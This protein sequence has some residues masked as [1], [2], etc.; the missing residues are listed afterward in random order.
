[1]TRRQAA[2]PWPLLVTLVLLALL[3]TSP[4]AA[5]L[6]D[7]A[8]DGWHTW[9]VAVAANVPEWCCYAWNSGIA[10]RTSCDLDGHLGGYHSA[11]DASGG[12]GQLQLYAL[13]DSGRATRIRALSPRC[14]ISAGTPVAD[15]GIV[16]TDDSVAWLTKQMTPRTGVSTH[17]IAALAAHPGTS[18]LQSL[19]TTVRQGPDFENRK[20]A[21]FWM[22]QLR[23]DD[24]A[25]TITALLFDDENPKLREHAAF[26]IS[27]SSLAGKAD[28][29]GRLGNTDR[30]AAVRAKA[31][32]WLAQTGAVNAEQQIVSALD[33]EEDRQVRREAIF[34]LSQL[35]ENRA[36]KALVAV[37]EDRSREQDERKQALF[38]LAQ[39]ESDEAFEYV[40]RILAGR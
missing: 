32:F 9:R 3:A 14:A 15:L 29:L 21:I 26:S 5:D 25:D 12:V 31:W 8:D 2:L 24:T 18:A 40:D 36:A 6:S 7:V 28:A 22:A 13:M 23:A 4:A 38:W 37:I 11:D 16:D 27:Q 34:A 39:S 20:D 17:A 35:P 33:T 30:D 19:T 10:Q 1:M